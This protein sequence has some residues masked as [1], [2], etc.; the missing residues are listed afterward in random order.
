MFADV[1]LNPKTIHS[2]ANSKLAH[3]DIKRRHI[4]LRALKWTWPIWAILG[5]YLGCGA[6]QYG[7]F[8]V[9]PEAMAVAVPAAIPLSIIFL[10]LL[11][12][13]TILIIFDEIRESRCCQVIDIVPLDTHA[14]TDRNEIVEAAV[15]TMDI[16]ELPDGI[17]LGPSLVISRVNTDNTIDASPEPAQSSDGSPKTAST[18]KRYAQAYRQVQSL[19]KSPGIQ[20]LASIRESSRER[21]ALVTP[22]STPPR[23]YSP[24]FYAAETPWRPSSPTPEDNE[25]LIAEL[26]PTLRFE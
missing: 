11:L 13:S 2:D 18:P 17:V 26:P 1:N 6:L 7:G 25:E 5:I 21:M 15:V 23:A 24:G 4:I 8:L 10:T 3:P 19:R 14:R 12:V 16:T 9:I 20:D 22:V